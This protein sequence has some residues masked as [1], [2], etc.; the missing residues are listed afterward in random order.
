MASKG[1]KRKKTPMPGKKT[2][3]KIRVTKNGP[4]VVS[5]GIPLDRQAI[6]CDDTGNA[7]GYRKEGTYPTKESYSLCRCGS[8][9]KHPFCDGSHAVT[10][11]EGTE[12][13]GFKKYSSLARTTEGP[14]L[15]LSD[16]EELCASARFCD[17]AGGVWHLTEKSDHPRAKKTAIQEVKYCPAGRLAIRDKKTGNFLEPDFDPSISVLEDPSVNSSGPLWVKGGIPVESAEGKK[18]ETRNRVTLCRCGESGNKPFC[19]GSHRAVQFDDGM[20]EG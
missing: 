10:G 16:A 14:E 5:G 18:Y 1:K 3:A 6:V 11:F 19:D 17:R 12:T 15:V 20:L 9:S 8:S 7:V 13:S 4:Y 2:R